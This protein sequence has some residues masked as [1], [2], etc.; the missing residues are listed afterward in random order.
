MGDSGTR[1]TEGKGETV[2]I[3]EKI[4]KLRREK[5]ALILAHNYQIAP[6][7][8][9]ADHRGDSL[10]LSVLAKEAK[11]KLIVFCGVRFM[12]ETAAILN[13]E[14]RVL[15][16][17]ADAGCPMA[18]MITAE[19]LIAFK[20]EH[21]G[22]KV[23]CYVNSSAAVKAESDVCCTSSN[24][25]KIISS[26]PKNE[27][28]LFVPDRNLGTWAAKQAKRD[29]IVWP[30]YC[31]VHQWG[32]TLRNLEHLRASHPG[33]R[34][35]AHP[36]CDEDIVKEA[37]EVLSTGQMMRYVEANDKLIIATDATFTDYLKHIYPAKEL[38]ALNHRARCRNMRKTTLHEL[39]L[40]LE[41][42]QFEVRV[43]PEVAAR[44]KHSL[45]RMLELSV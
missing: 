14:A 32:F 43:P 25:V 15:L 33:Y 40:A 41:K 11:S 26:F 3:S 18:D 21:P 29:V 28:I 22:A 24:A 13:P 36:E 8:D 23:V 38:V 2:N 39:L 30:G 45:D 44:A 9:L 34:L 27:T 37:D 1:D 35:I 20:A 17:A 16:P 42:E 12:A 6:I 31:P 7:Q 19:Q 10:Q 5:G 4:D